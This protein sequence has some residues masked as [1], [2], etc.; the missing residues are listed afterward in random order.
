MRETCFVNERKNLVEMFE[1]L[2]NEQ[3]DFKNYAHELEDLKKI[4]EEA[5]DEESREKQKTFELEKRIK[6]LSNQY[7]RET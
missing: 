5:K 4:V 3:E 6:E 2:R 1:N 7:Q